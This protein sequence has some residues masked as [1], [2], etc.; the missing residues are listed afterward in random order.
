MGDEQRYLNARQAAAYLGVKRQRVY[1]L[2][3]AGRLLPI[4]PG[5]FVFT[6]AA[7]DQ[8][9]QERAQRP[10]GGRPPKPHPTDSSSTD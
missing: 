5:L 7:L 1:D 3:A 4:S 8:Y 9:K 6:Q 2:V 10:K